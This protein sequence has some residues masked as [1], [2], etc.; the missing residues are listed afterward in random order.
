VDYF[1]GTRS[2]SV[3]AGHSS[4]SFT[5]DRY[6]HLY[7]NAEQVFLSKLNA[8]TAGAVP[9]RGTRTARQWLT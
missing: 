6:G 4:V 1:N 8:A 5:L 7:P 9:I 2:V 3:L